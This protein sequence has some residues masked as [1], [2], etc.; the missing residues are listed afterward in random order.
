MN[1]NEE[2]SFK[3][4]ADAHMFDILRNKIYSDKVAAVA[5]EILSNSIDANIE[6]NKD[7]PAEVILPNEHYKFIEFIDSGKGIPPD[8]IDMFVTYGQSTKRNDA[9][10]RGAF[11]MGAKTSN[12][13]SNESFVDTIS[14]DEKQNKN[15]L[16]KYRVYIDDSKCG[17][18]QL[19]SEEDSIK[20]TGT[21]IRIPVKEENF[22]SFESNILKLS[23]Y[24]SISPKVFKK[25]KDGNLVDVLVPVRTS[26]LKGK[27]WELSL[28]NSAS[29][30]SHSLYTFCIAGVPYQYDFYSLMYNPTLKLAEKID[31][32]HYQFFNNYT[33][34]ILVNYK[35]KE[36][37]VSVSRE[38]VE[39]K[40]ESLGTKIAD[41]LKD[42][43][44]EAKDSLVESIKN[45]KDLGQARN[46]FSKG[47]KSG[48]LKANKDEIDY[49]GI[50]VKTSSEDFSPVISNHE[51]YNVQIFTWSEYKKKF[52][53]T[54]SNLVYFDNETKIVT[55]FHNKPEIKAPVKN[56][57]E[58]IREKDSTVQ[59]VVV[60]NATNKKAID[61]VVSAVTDLVE[62]C[63]FDKYETTDLYSYE[64][65]ER[66]KPVKK[67]KNKY[68]SFY[69]FKPYNCYNE[70]IK[71]ESPIFDKPCVY[72]RYGVKEE[73]GK[74]FYNFDKTKEINHNELIAISKMSHNYITLVDKEE[75]EIPEN[76]IELEEF[77][78]SK[79]ESYLNDDDFISSVDYCYLYNSNVNMSEMEMYKPFYSS[80]LDESKLNETMKKSVVFHNWMENFKYLYKY[81]NV[82]HYRM[83]VDI[84]NF[85]FLTKAVLVFNPESKQY[86]IEEDSKKL[87]EK[88]IQS[89][90]DLNKKYPLIYGNLSGFSYSNIIDR[91]TRTLNI[92]NYIIAMS[93]KFN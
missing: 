47:C 10:A 22:Y 56:Y 11:G 93:E 16:R 72:V 64:L 80:A 25:D 19:L 4:S 18:I 63:N 71:E 30:N 27:D 89:I 1:I 15:I 75:E 73:K 24:A 21:T 38:S 84:E 74:V 36:I 53:Q 77:I 40:D 13:T 2:S 88:K 9:V 17:K 92:L 42:I 55:R 86:D 7:V 69:I 35:A 12:L 43:Y 81:N 8:K 52:T 49:K 65:S 23:S 32:S 46:L 58:A 29:Y 67:P 79:I 90:S 54:Y 82:D 66:L 39:I 20:E 78:Q 48:L 14:F 85:K 57:V 70:K 3:I 50:K 41:K 28:N 87:L 33:K 61:N 59:T 44:K 68:S 62:K 26:D 34:S 31:D 76:W 91:K 6:N 45:A 37:P 60:I 51:G 83:R 5:R